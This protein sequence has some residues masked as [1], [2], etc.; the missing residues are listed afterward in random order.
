MPRSATGKGP[1]QRFMH[2]AQWLRWHFMRGV[3]AWG[4]SSTALPKPLMLAFAFTPPAPSTPSA[5]SGAP[6][7]P[8]AACALQAS[9]QPPCL[10]QATAPGAPRGLRRLA[11]AMQWAAQRHLQRRARRC[12]TD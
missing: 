5:P 1:A 9:G 8:A 3:D 12:H 4:L 6:A 11:L 2:N 10:A 7:H